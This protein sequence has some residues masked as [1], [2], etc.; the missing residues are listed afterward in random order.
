MR[1][2]RWPTNLPCHALVLGFSGQKRAVSRGFGFKDNE[3]RF[4]HDQNCVTDRDSDVD[5]WLCTSFGTPSILLARSPAD[6]LLLS[7]YHVPENDSRKRLP[8]APS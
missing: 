1:H 7:I 5:Q 4:A 3:S 2:T 6:S 8:P